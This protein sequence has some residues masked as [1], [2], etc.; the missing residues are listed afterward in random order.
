MKYDYEIYSRLNKFKGKDKIRLHMPG[1]KN[2]GEFRALF[3]VA[4]IDVTELSFSDNLGDPTGVIGKA[5]ND[6]AEILGARKAY[7]TTDGSSSGVMALV[8]AASKRGNKLIVPRNSHKSVYNACRLLGVEPVIVQGAEYEGVLLPPPV[9][10]IEKLIVNDVN[11][12]GLFITS[13]DYYGNIAPLE[14]YA[15]V[16][17]KHS[18][19]LLADGAHGAHLFLEEGRAGYAGVYAD[20]WVD[21]AHKTLPTLTQGAVV[22]V[23]D[24]EIV[25][26][27]G[28][29][30]NLFRTTSP[31][32]PVMASVEYGVK[33]YVN[34]PKI[35][36]RAKNAVAEFKSQMTAF[37]FY[38]S[39]DWTKIALD[40]KPLGISPYVAEE[41]LEKRGIYCEMNDGRYLLFYLSPSVEPMQL[42]E[43]RSALLWI[44]A[45]KKF[46]QTY[47]EKLPLPSADR[48]YSYLYAL[49]SRSEYVAPKDAV[50][51]MC[52]ENAGITPPCIPV[53]VA[54]EM[55]SSAAV[56]VL[57]AAK[58]T[59]GLTDGKI[60]VV[61]RDDR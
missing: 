45:Q 3:P 50:G 55:I 1:H 9:E 52:A 40:F 22:C 12:A 43:L 57:V 53:I 20:G 10:L 18:R 47:R 30:L 46:K 36:D 23:N 51:R 26:D 56:N 38:P 58:Q 7:I 25:A 13:P 35:F 32:Y 28:E 14:E 2:L 21:G 44:A 4:P 37:T 15:D 5:Q 41:Q 42:F 11:I 39:R 60:K 48:T 29:G 31:S 49:K 59:F 8:Y 54:G 24:A 17:K 6:L 61:K 27:V 19:L 16:L 33:Y 34:N